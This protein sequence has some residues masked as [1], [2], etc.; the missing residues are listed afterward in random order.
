MAEHSPRRRAPKRTPAMLKAGEFWLVMC[1][2]CRHPGSLHIAW[3]PE[4]ARCR[5]CP[6]CPGY[7]DGE[8]GRWSDAKTREVQEQEEGNG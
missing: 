4:K 2:A 3:P 6:D 1:A 5:C 7:V 8:Y